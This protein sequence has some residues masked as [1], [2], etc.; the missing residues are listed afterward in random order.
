MT[1]DPKRVKILIVTRNLPPLVGGMER[2]NW[3]MAEQLSRFCEICVVGPIGSKRL[4]PG[5]VDIQEVSLRPLWKFLLLAQVKALKLARV[6]RPT[7]VLAGSGLTAPLALLAARMSGARAV[8]YVHGLDIAL[9]RPVY[10]ALWLP[11]IRKMDRVIANSTATL[12]LAVAAGIPKHR[13]A[14]VHPGVDTPVGKHGNDSASSMFRHRHGLGSGPLLLSV[15]RLTARKGLREFV[16]EVLPQVAARYPAVQ[17]VVVGGNAKDALAANSQTPASIR[18]AAEQAGVG[19]HLHILG[20]IS[21][22]ELAEAY[23]AVSVHVFP[24]REIP[25]DPEGFGMVA[26]EAA[27]HG[28]PTIAYA[29]GGVVD[30]VADGISGYLARVGDP[31]SMAAGIV[32]ALADPL[33]AEPMQEFAQKFAWHRFGE[34]M[35]RELHAA[36]VLPGSG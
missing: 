28:V 7:T 24:V 8:A 9:E 34:H 17:L 21:D 12:S 20:P 2:L 29:T 30:A 33:R 13:V 31:E 3:H 18:A 25:G 35:L 23:R 27:A 32:R 19:G 22:G 5:G 11:A 26:I 6:W 14:V 15:G 1:S 4:G 16:Q 36:D 10:R